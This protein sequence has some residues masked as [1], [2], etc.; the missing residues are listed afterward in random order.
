M[1]RMKLIRRKLGV[2]Q[3]ALATMAKVNQST[4]SRWERGDGEPSLTEARNIIEASGGVIEA[5]DFFPGLPVKRK[6]SAA[7]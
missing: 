3:A 4:V 2:S 7:A 6:R 5:A 1:N